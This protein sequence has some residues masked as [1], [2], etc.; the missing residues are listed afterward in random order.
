MS[1]KKKGDGKKKRSR[2]KTRSKIFKGI[3]ITLI[4][5]LL[6]SIAIGAGVGYG[7]IKTAPEIDVQKFLEVEETSTIYD[8][9]GILMDEFNT[10]E[11]RIS[12][13]IDKVPKILKDAFISIEDERFYSHKGIDFRRLGGAF[14][15]D[16]KIALGLSDGSLQ[17]ASTITQQLVKYRYFLEDSLNNRTSIKRKVQEMYLA[18]KLEKQYLTKE[19][20][21]ESYMNTIFLGG[22]AHGI[23][24]ASKM[25]FSKS[26]DK[27]TIKQAAFIAGAAQNP[28][29]SFANAFRNY[30]ENTPF[31]SPRTKTVLEK[32]LETGAINQGEYDQAMAEDL[33][34]NFSLKSNNKMNYEYFSRPVIEEVVKDLMSVYGYNKE[35]AYDE[36]MYGGYRVYTTMDKALQDEIQKVIDDEN[37]ELISPYANPNLQASAVIM[38]YKS[39]EV[40]CIIGGRGDQPA[41]SYNRAASENFLRAPG[42]SLKP[43]TIYAPAIDSQKLTAGSAFEDAPVPTEMGSKYGNPPYD[44]KNSP[45]MY[46]GY[47]TMRDSIRVSANTIAVRIGDAIGLDLA[48]EYGTKFGI[49]LDDDDKNS[50][51]ALALGQLDGG[52]LNGTNPLAL[53]S[54]YGA[55]GNNGIVTKPKLYTKVVD[56]NGK[57]ILESKPESNKVISPETAYIMFDMLKEPIIGTGPS[58]NFGNMP[59]RG[60]TGTSSDSKDLW[61]TGLTPYYSCA[62]WMGNDDYTP[63][64]GM[65]SDNPSALWGRI[66]AIAHRDLPYKEID[67][68]AGVINVDVSRDSGTLPTDLSYRDPRGDRVYSELF[69]SGTQPTTLDDIHVEADVVKGADGRYY[70]P[71]ENTPK[72]RIERRVF[73]TRDYSPSVYLQDS[74]WVLPTEKDPTKYDTI[75]K[76]KDKD[77][78]KNKDKDKDKDKDKNKDKDKD[79]DKDEEI[80]EN[81]NNDVQRSNLQTMNFHQSS[82]INSVFKNISFIKF[83]DTI[84]SYIKF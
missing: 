15:A 29:V 56:R 80:N 12:V 32:M 70:L 51:S 52:A 81:D 36:L 3:Y 47:V 8:N 10:P 79:K 39:G 17:G 55:F 7:I 58:A 30:K 65:N 74:Q 33:L 14:I 72:E 41:N 13:S 1:E 6:G 62:V 60:K 44:P 83:I 23:E 49:H 84:S 48:S 46:R 76:G 57:T 16:V 35:K 40:K 26:V 9:K 42:S 20:I 11:K 61:F 19:Q 78:D 34:F 68:P 18:Y 53:S 54:A 67:R 27:L 4:I 77:K 82:N 28:S 66:M 59:I 69:I 31:D 5:V 64:E 24:A 2:K 71:S 73:I 38:D 45:D 50:M 43:L 21:L 75:D 63:V 25:Y 22:S 37:G